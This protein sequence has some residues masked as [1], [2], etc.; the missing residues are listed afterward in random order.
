M[1]N[2]DPISPLSQYISSILAT[3]R[4]NIALQYFEDGGVNKPVFSGLLP[5]SF[6]SLESFKDVSGV[7]HI[8]GEQGQDYVG[9]SLDLES[10]LTSQHRTRALNANQTYRH[11]NFYSDVL[12]NG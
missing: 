8:I 10:R 4:E 11:P 9:S 7:Y 12:K 5:E 1:V 2:Q 6:Y 3:S